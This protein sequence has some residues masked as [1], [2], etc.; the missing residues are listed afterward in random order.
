MRIIRFVADD[1]RIHHG[2]PVADHIA[3]DL[4]G[5]IAKGFVRTD[6]RLSITKLL[7][8]LEPR[9]LICIGRNYKGKTENRNQKAE[10]TNDAAPEDAAPSG[11]A[12]VSRHATTAQSSEE[13]GGKV[14]AE[15]RSQKTEIELH[16]HTLEVFL[17]PSTALQNPFDPIL[18]PNFP[19]IDP[20]LDCEG[21][22]A[23]IIGREARNIAERDAP[24]HIFGYTIANDVTARAFQTPTG[25]PL[26]M[27]GK[28]FDTF[29]PI[30]PAIVTADD[31]ADPSDLT[32]RT[33]ING[34]V[35]REGNT[36]DMIRTVPQIIAALSRHMTLRAGAIILTGAPPA[37]RPLGVPILEV[38]VEI[39]GLT[40]LQNPILA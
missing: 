40:S 36:R 20:Q 37:L 33:I 1:G 9:D 31:I 32:I 6:H 13:G 34:Q 7:A 27:R 11:R 18:I 35:V 39:E 22:L 4:T 12:P 8:P 15:T 2:E 3:V 10:T 14:K 19:G 5:S 25:P 23:V 21:E 30:G 28:G 29:C 17:K 38:M 26:W 16:D 24:A